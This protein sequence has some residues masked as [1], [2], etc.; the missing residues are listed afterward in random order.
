MGKLTGIFSTTF[1]KRLSYEIYKAEPDII[2]K[3]IPILEKEFGFYNAGLPVVGLDEIF[4]EIFCKNEKILIGW[5]IWSGFFINSFN[6]TGDDVVRAVGK[7]LDKNI[8]A[9]K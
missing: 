2:Y 3:I 6:D 1:S 4:I 8:E 7:Y 9:L 5:D